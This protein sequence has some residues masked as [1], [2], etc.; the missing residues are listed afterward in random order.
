MSSNRSVA[1]VAA[2]QIPPSAPPANITG[3][4]GW[5]KEN[6]FDGVLNS[7]LTVASIVV[8]ILLV[9]PIVDWAFLKGVWNASSLSQCREIIVA[10]H[11]EGSTG[12]CWAVI[13]ERMNQFIFGFYPPELYWR[14]ILAFVLLFVALAPVLFNG[15][16]RK[17]LWFTAS[18]PVIA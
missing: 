14:P 13:N 6:L 2:G 17:M 12:A 18:F 11:G 15:I 16:P 7:I 10:T 9:P 5:L 3:P 1:F 8:I 4:I